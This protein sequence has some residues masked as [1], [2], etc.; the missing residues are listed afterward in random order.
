MKC[1]CCSWGYGDG[2][3]SRN[4]VFLKK[5][6]SKP[7]LPSTQYWIG[8]NQSIVSGPY[9][10]EESAL[11]AAQQTIE[12]RCNSYT[13]LFVFKKIAVARCTSVVEKLA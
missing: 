13:E 7:V 2:L 9:S 1:N 5:E 4:C 11:S 8:T 12:S 3:H 6:E 10:S